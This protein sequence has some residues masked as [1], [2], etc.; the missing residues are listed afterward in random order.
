MI[1]QTNECVGC[2]LDM[3]CLYYT[4]PYKNTYRFKCDYCGEE[5]VKLYKYDGY[6]ICEECLLKEFEVVEGSDW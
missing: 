4:C 3:G 2:P 6:Q 5:D 1:Y